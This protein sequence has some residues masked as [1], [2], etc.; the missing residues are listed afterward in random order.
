MTR[1]L[2]ATAVPSL[3]ALTGALSMLCA[4]AHASGVLTS[5]PEAD[6]S[7]RPVC[8]PPA[9]FTAGCLALE[10]VPRAAPTH[11]RPRP[12]A[13]AKG[14][15]SGVRAAAEDDPYGLRPQDLHSVYQLPDTA[16][17]PQTIALVEAYNDPDAEADLQSYDQEFALPACTRSNGCLTQVNQDG[18]ATNLPFPQSED[19]LIE[20]EGVCATHSGAE[21]EAA[22]EEV[23]PA[24]GWIGEMSLDLEVAHGICQNCRIALV[25][26]SSPAETDL[27]AA[28]DTAA[29]S[30]GMG[31]VGANEISN[32]W[33]FGE[34]VE[35][36]AGER[37]CVRGDAAFNHPGIVITAA[38]GDDGYLSWYGETSPKGF[39]EYPAASPHVVS[40]GG[41][42]LELLEDEGGGYGWGAETVWNGDGAGG[43]GCSLTFAAAPWQQSLS[44]WSSVGCGGGR[45]VAD[46]S[47]DAD[48]FTGV[49]VYDTLSQCESEPGSGV[50]VHWCTIG[51]T[52]LSSPL[53]AS[54]FALA[55]GAGAAPYPAK[56]LYEH[57]LSSPGSLHDIATGS[58]G[59]CQA[60]YQEETGLSGCEASEE[61][62]SCGG[63]AICVAQS[64]YDGPTGLGTPDGLG[65]FQPPAGDDEPPTGPSEP[66][67]GPS[68]TTASPV[69]GGGGPV[70]SPLVASTPAVS[71][72]AVSLTGLTLTTN[73]IVALNSSRPRIS[74]VGFVFDINAGAHVRAVLAER[75]RV[76]RRT[77][78]QTLPSSITI[79]ATTGRN[80]R[81][82]SGHR[83]LSAGVYR[84]T[85]TPTGG[86]ARSL[87]FQIG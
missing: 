25:E 36:T 4:T 23:A 82:L 56:T 26:A 17:S 54:V 51:G 28:E 18:E 38:A 42:H 50:L 32:S 30:T 86:P 61:G 81:R 64:G 19:A 66:P 75:V 59:E 60:P 79:A 45:A 2:R 63:Q 71:P 58:N 69:S 14:S 37:E 77:R 68:T 7:V 20:R 22:C 46:I 9:P 76:H 11:A 10:L 8:A 41:T 57:E 24:K 80:S 47:A 12:L 55:G 13:I 29:G 83:V 48:P 5:L 3:L 39:A 40:V 44:D 31:G 43:G 62:R 33:G 6:Y 52:S 84:L 78:W 21:S 35:P 72:L 34:C 85:L 87:T 27:E 70:G 1:T 15:P 65:A 73:A 16:P 53:I 74:Q 49:A 67:T